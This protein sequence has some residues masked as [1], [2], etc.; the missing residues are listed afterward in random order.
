MSYNYN[1]QCTTIYHE[2]FYCIQYIN[3][4][5]TLY[6]TTAMMGLHCFIQY[7]KLS[8]MKSALAGR[9]RP[10]PRAASAAAAALL[11]ARLE[12]S[13]LKRA[14]DCSVRASRARLRSVR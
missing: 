10:A 3:G 12:S 8:T 7:Y 9:I 11:Q 14:V 6:Y 1:T 4:S 5:L 13:D 2:T